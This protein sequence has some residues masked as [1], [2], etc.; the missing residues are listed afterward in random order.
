MSKHIHI[1]AVAGYLVDGEYFE[2]RNEAYDMGLHKSV[3]F[4]PVVKYSEVTSLQDINAELVDALIQ[5]RHALQL[6]NDMPNGPV[7]D[8]IWMPHSPETLF[9]FMD[10]AI[11][12][13]RGEV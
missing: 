10:A 2:N 1:V 9:D 8:T 12:K 5:S 3:E 13:A 7:Q 11:A 4:T 6:A